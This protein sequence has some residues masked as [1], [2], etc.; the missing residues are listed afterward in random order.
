MANGPFLFVIVIIFTLFTLAVFFH[1]CATLSWLSLLIRYNKTENVHINAFYGYAK[2]LKND[3]FWGA[4][5][6]GHGWVQPRETLRIESLYI[7]I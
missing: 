7:D 3:H 4:S 1:W 2:M 6:L 5:L